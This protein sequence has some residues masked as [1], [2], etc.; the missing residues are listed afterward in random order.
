MLKR[1]RTQAASMVHVAPAPAIQ[2]SLPAAFQ[3][4]PPAKITG[5]FQHCLRL[6]ET[7]SFPKQTD[8]FPIEF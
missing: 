3:V 8:P 4:P 1:R 7:D 2:V 5:V 6:R